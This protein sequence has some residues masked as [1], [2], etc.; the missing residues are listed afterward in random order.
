MPIHL[1]YNGMSIVDMQRIYKRY[2]GVGLRYV[3]AVILSIGLLSKKKSY[4][5]RRPRFSHSNRR[6]P[7]KSLKV[8]TKLPTPLAD[9][10]DG[11]VYEGRQFH[12]VSVRVSVRV[13]SLF[14]IFATE[15]N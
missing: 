12:S 10:E 11:A 2:T 8:L 1:K 7:L 5:V 13:I 6:E 3:H 15:A 9:L 4:F 14:S